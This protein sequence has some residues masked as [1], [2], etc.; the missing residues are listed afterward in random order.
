MSD[1]I[2]N[3]NR[4][5]NASDRIYFSV[6]GVHGFGIENVT[7][8]DLGCDFFVAGTHKWLFG[9]R[10][11]GIIWAKEDAWDMVIPTI[12]AFSIAYAVWLGIVPERNLSF[13]DLCTPGGFHA[14]E[15]RWAL[16]EA[17]D[18][19]MKIGKE[20]IEKRTHQLSSTLKEG[21]HDLDHVKLRTPLTP[22]ISAGINCFEV[23]GMP[24]QEVVNKLSEQNIIASTSP[25]RTSYAR[26]TPCITNTEGEVM[27]CIK[28]IEKIKS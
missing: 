8:E 18:F 28:A 17:F 9:P 27:T 20:K 25:Y 21:L 2:K 23:D 26:L 24:P 5:R 3:I 15:H 10:G 6:D 22:D 16:N 13:S 19:H 11:T 14:F 12:P 1:A 4:N 7:M